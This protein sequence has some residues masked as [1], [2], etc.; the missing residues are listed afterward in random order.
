MGWRGAHPSILSADKAGRCPSDGSRLCSG[1]GGGGLPADKAG[2]CPS[3]GSR[4]C[5]GTGGGGL[6]ADKAGPAPFTGP[7]D[8][9]FRRAGSGPGLGKDLCIMARQRPTR[10]DRRLR[11]AGRCPSDCSR[12]CPRK[13]GRAL[14]AGKVEAYPRIRV[15]RP[16]NAP[17]GGTPGSARPAP[18]LAL[19]SVL[20]SGPFVPVPAQLYPRISSGQPPAPPR[21][22]VTQSG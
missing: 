18:R 16:Q 14:S 10:P 6:S 13:Q 17:P 20:K 3:D 7:R 15:H 12:L 19:P 9:A 1:T 4:L 2:H 8:P 22:G 5:S 21:A 11:R